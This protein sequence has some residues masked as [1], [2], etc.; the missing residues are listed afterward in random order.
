MVVAL[1]GDEVDFVEHFSVAGGKA[2]LDNPDVQVIAIST[3]THRQLHM[4]TDK[5]PF[6]DA[7]VR[8]AIALAIDRNALVDGLWEGRADIGNDSPFAPAL[9]LDRHV[10]PAAGAGH[11][12]GEAAARRRRR[13]GLHGAARHLG[14]VRDPR[15]RAAR[16]ERG[17]GDRRHDQPEHHRRRH[18]L[19]RRRL[20]EVDR[21]S[22][23]SWASPTTATGRCRTST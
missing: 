9:P 13:R 10:R 14:R 18:V 6:T 11:R 23:P 4:R 12:A 15:P 16:E 2:L 3:A 20:R 19:R 5:E 22:T 1:Q 21:G 8:Q 17:G 7:R